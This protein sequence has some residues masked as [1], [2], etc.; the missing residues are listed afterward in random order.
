MSAAPAVAAAD[1]LGLT[2]FLAAAVH[3][4]VIL[5]VGFA[6]GPGPDAS[7]ALEVVMLQQSTDSEPEQADYLANTDSAGGGASEEPERPRAPVSSPEQAAQ[8]GLA[9]APLEAGAP[10][11][12]P[13]QPEA[14]VT[15]HAGERSMADAEQPET[16]SEPAPKQQDEKVEQD[17]QVAKLAA[18]IDNALNEYAQ[19]PRKKF[20]TA[21]ARQSPAAAYMHDWVRSVERLGNTNYPEAARREGLAGA[22]VLVVAVRP[23]GSLHEVRVQA[24]SGEPVLDAA[25]QRIV[26]LAA[27]FEAFSDPLRDKTD[28]LY[29]TRTWEFTPG[30]RLNADAQAPD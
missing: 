2:L 10:Q 8:A 4:L 16:E 9:P 11:P 26:R 21:Q 14:V 13:P 20:V 22:L 25:A 6:F 24:S 17:A 18:E 27:P 23:D 3:G 30:N 15:S 12:T 1:R 28:I 29:I 5:G 7:R 19:R